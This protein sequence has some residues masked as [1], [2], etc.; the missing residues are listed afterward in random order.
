MRTGTPN[1]LY[2]IA[3]Q[4]TDLWEERALPILRYIAAHE[5]DM[6]FISIGDLSAALGIGGHALAAGAADWLAIP[7]RTAVR[8]ALDAAEAVDKRI[9]ELSED[10]IEV[11]RPL[12][13]PRMFERFHHREEH[14]SAIER[15]PT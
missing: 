8:L 15:V 13:N 5:T 7:P 12:M 1:F 4:P 6:G 9:E 14:L 2:P 11:A 3:D 10:L